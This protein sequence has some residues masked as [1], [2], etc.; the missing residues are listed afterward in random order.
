MGVV[1]P[2]GEV[3]HLTGQVAWD[4][5]EQII[6]AGDIEKQTRCC[7]E[8][9]GKLLKSVGGDMGDI[10]SI[11]TYFTDRSQ[12]PVIQKIRSEYLTVD[13]EPVSTSVMVAGLGHADF[14]VELTPIALSAR[15][16]AAVADFNCQAYRAKLAH[17]IE[18]SPN[19]RA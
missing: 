18:N 6:G 8:N 5:N 9:I 11:T 4:E 2:D 7:F 12:L 17:I 10:V 16:R 13:S 19:Q 14:L 3:V 1:Q 15:A